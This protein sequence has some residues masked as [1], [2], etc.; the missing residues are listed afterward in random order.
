[1]MADVEVMGVDPRDE[2]WG[3]DAPRYRVYFHDARGASDEHELRD[4]DVDEVIAWAEAHQGER[5]CVVYAC[6]RRD[7]LGLVRLAGTDPNAAPPPTTSL[8]DGAGSPP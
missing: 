1:M 7:G 2:T 3:V 6:V 4:A 5:T 8:P